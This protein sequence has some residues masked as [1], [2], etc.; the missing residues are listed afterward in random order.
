MPAV[1]RALNSSF[2]ISYGGARNLAP[3]TILEHRKRHSMHVIKRLLM[4]VPLVG[5][6]LAYGDQETSCDSLANVV[7]QWPVAQEK[8]NANMIEISLNEQGNSIERDARL[9]RYQHFYDSCLKNALNQIDNYLKTE[10]GEELFM[11]LSSVHRFSMDEELL[12]HLS[13]IIDTQKQKGQVNEKLTGYLHAVLVMARRFDQ[14]RALE[15]TFPKIEFHPTATLTDQSDGGIFRSILTYDGSGVNLTREPFKL[16]D[17]GFVVFGAHTGCFYSKQ[18]VSYI[19][20]SPELTTIFSD[21]SV[22]IKS[23][24]FTLDLVAMGQYNDSI[25]PLKLNYIYSVDDWPEIP[26]W[27][28]P[29]LYFYF[30]GELVSHMSGWAGDEQGTELYRHLALVGLHN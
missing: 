3:F 10:S 28:T 23:P 2:I 11:I 24:S 4:L 18:L 22:L 15:Q 13:T 25:A 12:P 27:N 21:R 30:D 6:T 8:I 26:N 17:G 14:A 9:D 20:A 1:N 19:Q 7:A 16:P 29:E 5:A